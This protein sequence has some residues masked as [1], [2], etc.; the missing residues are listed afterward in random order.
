ME[1]VSQRTCATRSG[2]QVYD[3]AEPVSEADA[4]GQPI[5]HRWAAQC[6]TGEAVFIDDIPSALGTS[7][8]ISVNPPLSSHH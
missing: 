3:V 2:S 8:D 7:S 1:S 4:V 5:H 6:S